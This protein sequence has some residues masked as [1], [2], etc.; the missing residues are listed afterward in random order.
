MKD[1]KSA[2]FTLVVLSGTFAEA[3]TDQPATTEAQVAETGFCEDCPVPTINSY[4]LLKSVKLEAESKD[5]RTDSL[6]SSSD[7][8]RSLVSLENL[9]TNKDSSGLSKLK[10]GLKF[11]TDDGATF[12]IGKSKKRILH[13]QKNF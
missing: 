5:V 11:Q 1:I 7:R 13:Y 2:L 4:D 8:R 3:A 9:P 6:R 10:D 12:T